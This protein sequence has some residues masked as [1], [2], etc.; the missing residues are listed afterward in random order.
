MFFDME[1]HM[2]LAQEARCARIQETEEDPAGAGGAAGSD[3]FL[4]P[5]GEQ[6]RRCRHTQ[7]PAVRGALR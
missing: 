7:A 4:R 6:A 1:P 3:A 2:C 5:Q